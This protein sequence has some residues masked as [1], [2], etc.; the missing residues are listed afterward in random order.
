M[1]SR[2]S[3]LVATIVT[4]FASAMIIVGGFLSQGCEEKAKYPNI[5]LISVD[6]L[7]ADRVGCYGDNRGI[8]GMMDFWAER[9]VRFETAYAPS[10][11]TL[12]SH[13]SAF[14]GLYPTEHMAIDEKINIDKTTPMLAEILQKAG[15]TTGAFVSHYYLSAEYGFDRGF[16]DFFIK[17]NATADEMVTKAIAWL[18]DNKNKNFFAFLHL[19]D[20]HTPYQPPQNF[21]KKHY[22]ADTGVFVSGTTKDVI[23]VIRT[24]PSERAKKVLKCLSA[25]YDGE[26]DFVDKQLEV[27]FKFMQ[28]NLLDQNTLIILFSDHGEEFMEHRLMEHGF[29]LYEEQLRVPVIFY[30]PNKL[31][32]GEVIKEPINLIDLMPTLLDFLGLP[33]LNKPISGRS[34]MPLIR[35]ETETLKRHLMAETTRQG[36]DRVAIIKDRYKYIY[37]PKFN[38]N[39]R[40]FDELLFN[41]RADPL[42][43]NNLIRE[44]KK[45]A[46]ALNSE[47]FST[48][49]Y[50]QR[51][52]WHLRWGK[53]AKPL[54]GVI[55]ST[56]KFIYTYKQNTIYGTDARGLLT[57][58]EFPLDKK[59]PRK[60]QF[61]SLVDR[62]NGISFMTDPETVP[63]HFQLLFAGREQAR[64]IWLGG[65]DQHPEKGSFAL[66]EQIDLT[67]DPHPP[68][69]VALIWSDVVWVNYKQVLRSEVGDPIKLS[70]EVIEQLRS[71]GYLTQ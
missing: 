44:E 50:V 51:R 66:A 28:Q 11:W 63:V 61:V 29:T 53:M 10:P 62:P 49:M 32:A 52:I 34:V 69:E 25:L 33:P 6:T 1:S 4:L 42:E 20:P 24:W 14:T 41:L 55:S 19:F 18:K 15:F 68:P 39:G 43:S 58:E 37:S 17:P 47:I 65:P 60:L 45:K 16:D 26:I 54:R 56:G 30:A 7:R 38:L 36:P 35:G 70:P 59:D 12:P 22:P 13:A 71:L 5:L 8:T 27:L 40:S 21:A 31:P 3:K 48:G 64:R 23:E 2:K 67:T 46:S 57:A 9:G